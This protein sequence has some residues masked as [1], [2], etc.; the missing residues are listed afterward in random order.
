MKQ[1]SISEAW[2]KRQIMSLDELAEKE[3]SIE[4]FF[5]KCEQRIEAKKLKME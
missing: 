2:R 4:A 5:E 3:T 1:V